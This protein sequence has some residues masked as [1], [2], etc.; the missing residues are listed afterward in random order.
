MHICMAFYV[1]GEVN[2]K[3]GGGVDSGGGGLDLEVV[4]NDS[5]MVSWLVEEASGR[6]GGGVDK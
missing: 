1:V 6:L 2:G 4:E 3:L 5:N